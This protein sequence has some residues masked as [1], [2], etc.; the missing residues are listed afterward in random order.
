MCVQEAPSLTD[1]GK[2]HCVTR[3]LD[4]LQPGCGKIEN[5]LPGNNRLEDK[6]EDP[7]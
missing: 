2:D 4:R 7:Q 6:P 3:H 5:E 1:P